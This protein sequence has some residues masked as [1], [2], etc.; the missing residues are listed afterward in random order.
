MEDFIDY[1]EMF[2]Y[3]QGIDKT[4]DALDELLKN[5]HAAAVIDLAQYALAAVEKALESADDSDGLLGDI[6]ERLQRLHHAASVKDKPDVAALA[7][8]LFNWE[9]R[10][11][12]DTFFG[13]AQTYAGVLG[14]R[15]LRVYRELARAQWAHIPALGPGAKDASDRGNRFRITAI[16]ETLARQ[17]GD[18][19]ELIAVKARNLS[20]AYSFLEIAEACREARRR[21][22]ALAWAERGLKA[23]LHRTDSR[24]R[25]FI[26]DEYHRRHRHD[27]ALALIWAN[28][29]DAPYL[30]C[31]RT[32]RAHARRVGQWPAWRHEALAHMRTVGEAAAR[33]TARRS[34]FQQ[35]RST[36]VEIL[37]DEKAVDEAWHEAN[38]CGCAERLWLQLATLRE[39]GHPKEAI[40][41]Y[42][43]QVEP[44]IQRMS[45]DA[46]RDAV[47]WLR[48]VHTLMQRTGQ[49]AEFD[50]YLAAVRA[51]HQRKRNFMRLLDH[52]RWR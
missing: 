33:N 36:L 3:A 11:Q 21:D 7:T 51:A 19:D 16:M 4:I 2:G 17:S 41:I 31:Y 47:G 40:A 6:L 24:L 42:R 27:E 46:Y 48:K 49:A 20:S 30:E 10:T 25:A 1:R 45:N 32:L 23:F 52:A 43:R 15:G 13:A 28:F 50:A 9:L 38:A 14:E 44:A 22:L 29:T 34:S 35:D 37:L 8:R 12:W 5:G 26:A 39:E 18:L